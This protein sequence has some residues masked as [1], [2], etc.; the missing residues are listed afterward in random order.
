LED[1]MVKAI[2]N[3]KEEESNIQKTEQTDAEETKLKGNETE[4]VEIKS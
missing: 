4:K 1:G 2:L 3:L